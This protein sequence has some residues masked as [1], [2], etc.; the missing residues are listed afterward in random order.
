MKNR[1]YCRDCIHRRYEHY[2]DI[3]DKC[4]FDEENKV[5][6]KVKNARNDC[7]DHEEIIVRKKENKS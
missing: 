4:A 6:C 1:V 3:R 7:E 2:G 5:S